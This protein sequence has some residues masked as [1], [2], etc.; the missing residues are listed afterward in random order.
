MKQE[1]QLVLTSPRDAMLTNIQQ[2]A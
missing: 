1:A 2:S